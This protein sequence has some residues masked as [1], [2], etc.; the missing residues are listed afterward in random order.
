M[1]REELDARVEA[2]IAK[3]ELILTM[4]ADLLQG[5]R[6]RAASKIL[7]EIQEEVALLRS[8]LGRRRNKLTGALRVFELSPWDSRRE[9]QQGG[10]VVCQ[11]KQKNKGGALEERVALPSKTSPRL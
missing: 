5:R 10:L 6:K 3:A 2:L 9:K 11:D 4:S 8:E 7:Q 1:T